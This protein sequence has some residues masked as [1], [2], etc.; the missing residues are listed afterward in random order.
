MSREYLSQC[1]SF[2]RPFILT[3][4]SGNM[5]AQTVLYVQLQITNNNIYIV[6][7]HIV[8]SVQHTLDS[9]LSLLAQ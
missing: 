4:I 5:Y 7:T 9:Q 8:S 2:Y 6:T 1:Y 3:H